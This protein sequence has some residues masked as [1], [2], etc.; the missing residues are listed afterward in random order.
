[1]QNP[2]EN[3]FMSPKSTKKISMFNSIYPLEIMLLHLWSKNNFLNKGF[4]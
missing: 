1:M 2:K 3:Y 4:C